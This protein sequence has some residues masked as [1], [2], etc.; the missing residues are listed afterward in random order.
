M[1]QHSHEEGRGEMQAKIIL[2]IVGISV[3]IIL[4]IIGFRAIRKRLA[5]SSGDDRRGDPAGTREQLKRDH[6]LTESA[7]EQITAG[8]EGLTEGIK[9][10]ESALE[11]VESAEERC[12]DI[13][14]AADRIEEGNRGSLD[15]NHSAGKLTKRN[16]QLLRELRKRQRNRKD[17]T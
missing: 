1:L 2:W 13:T 4:C 12:E 3:L 7:G 6:K 10:S 15:D 5:G 8:G 9:R 14:A 17:G 11:R 16:E